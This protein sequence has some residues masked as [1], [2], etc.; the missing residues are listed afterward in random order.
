MCAYEIFFFYQFV[1][2]EPFPHHLLMSLI[3]WKLML[4]Y[5][6]ASSGVR[7]KV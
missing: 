1:L 6:R 2:C 7:D 4:S 5:P 3:S